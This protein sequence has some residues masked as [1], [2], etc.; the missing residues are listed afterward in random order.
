MGFD[1][2]CSQHVAEWLRTLLSLLKMRRT[3]LTLDFILYYFHAGIEISV[4]VVAWTIYMIASFL[5]KLH[6]CPIKRK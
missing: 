3:G 2:L 4:V 5:W 6:S 1:A